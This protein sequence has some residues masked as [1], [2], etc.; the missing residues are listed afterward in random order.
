[1]QQVFGTGYRSESSI[2]WDIP[3]DRRGSRP[4]P[5]RRVESRG[6]LLSGCLVLKIL[7]PAD[8][9][10]PSRD[11]SIFSLSCSV[12]VIIFYKQTVFTEISV[13]DYAVLGSRLISY[14]SVMIRKRKSPRYPH[15]ITGLLNKHLHC[16]MK[17]VCEIFIRCSLPRS[18]IQT[19]KLALKI[20][21]L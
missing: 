19:H 2:S 5:F 6:S 8:S 20:N 17:K 10:F 15:I 14:V 3:S 12:A 9:F 4:R 1:M 11:A 18:N 13:Y 21:A 16:P 7:I